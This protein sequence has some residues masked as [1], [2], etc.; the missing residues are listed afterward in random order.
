MPQDAAADGLV[1]LGLGRLRA[2][3]AK[4]CLLVE[5]YGRGLD[6]GRAQDEFPI[7]VPCRRRFGMIEQFRQMG[8]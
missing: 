1:G 5:R 4:I 6:L 3:Q 7:A 8:Q 2:D